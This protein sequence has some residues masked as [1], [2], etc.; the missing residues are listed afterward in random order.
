VLV[1]VDK[2]V[3]IHNS[4]EVVRAMAARWQPGTASKILKNAVGLSTDPSSMGDSNNTG[5]NS[6]LSSK[7]IVDATRQWPEE[8][9]P[10]KFAP[11]N[12]DCLLDSFPDALAVA[13]NKWGHM[14][15]AQRKKYTN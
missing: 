9:G 5:Y 10:E 11:M 12:K 8:G 14:I 13:E 15:T 7:I 1:V 3:N 4:L 6:H 2:D